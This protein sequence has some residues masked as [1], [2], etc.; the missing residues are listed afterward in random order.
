MT[1]VLW[2]YRTTYK[3]PTKATPY[4]LVFGVEAVLPLEVELPSL[5]VA[6]QNDLTQEQ[7]DRLR[8]E[9]LDALDE[10]RLQAQQNLEIYRG[11]MAKSFDRMRSVAKVLDFHRVVEVEY[12]GVQIALHKLITPDFGKLVRRARKKLV[13]GD[14]SIYRAT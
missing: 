3:T 1:E 14:T 13:L 4:S 11:R 9:E 6:I 12:V 5:C 8:M 2:A 7:H 10:I